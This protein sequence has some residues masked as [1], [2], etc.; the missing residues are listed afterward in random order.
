MTSD[1]PS[2]ILYIYSKS[3]KSRKVKFP[4]SLYIKSSKQTFPVRS[5]FSPVLL[6]EHLA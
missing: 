3:N 6:I 2:F 4:G 1:T 5:N